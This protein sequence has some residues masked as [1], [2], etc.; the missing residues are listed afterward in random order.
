M[1]SRFSAGLAASAVVAVLLLGLLVGRALAG[2]ELS[3][4][5]NPNTVDICVADC[6]YHPNCRFLETTKC[7][8]QKV[9]KHCDYYFLWYCSTLAT[10]PGT[11]A[12]D[13]NIPCVC[14]ISGPQC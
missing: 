1:F 11:C 4:W 13:T 12:S 14:A 3:A 8:G 2:V 9:T 10:C 7:T 5:C 6:T